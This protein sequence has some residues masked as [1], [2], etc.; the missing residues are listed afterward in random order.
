MEK[1]EAITDFA[2]RAHEGQRRKFIDEPY[3]NHLIRVSDFCREVTSELPVIAAA[4][5]HDL[6]EDTA[7]TTGELSQFLSEQFSPEETRRTLKL[8]QELTDIYTHGD[9]PELNRDKRKTREAERL[10]KI[11]ATAQ[12]I[13]YAD[14]LDNSLDIMKS[15]SGFAP[16]YLIEAKM[17]LEKM[18]R[19]NKELYKRAKE[20]VTEGLRKVRGR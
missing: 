12:T 7:V 1:L 20:A 11:S 2:R 8:V 19:G 13:K 15:G 14:I 6:L 4:V 17:N 16:K 3:I 9:Y 18:N 10:G 5:L